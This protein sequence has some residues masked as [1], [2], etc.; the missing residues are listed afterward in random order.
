[1]KVNS[2]L[3]FLN[4]VPKTWAVYGAISVPIL[5]IV[6]TTEVENGT[7]DGEV[8]A[9]TLDIVETIVIETEIPT[10]MTPILLTNKELETLNIKNANRPHP[11]EID[12]EK[13]LI[14]CGKAM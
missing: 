4:S 6:M 7:C 12:K 5:A 2:A 1:M 3:L 14:V 13:F 11:M 8:N 10:S 9:P